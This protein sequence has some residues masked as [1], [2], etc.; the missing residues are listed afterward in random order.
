MVKRYPK[1]IFLRHSQLT[2]FPKKKD[3]T[4][5]T[6]ISSNAHQTIQAFAQNDDHEAFGRLAVYFTN[7]F[8][9]GSAPIIQVANAPVFCVFPDFFSF[10]R[11]TRCVARRKQSTA[12]K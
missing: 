2:L 4:E 12:M 7:W 11:I 1:L 5:S 10:V 3:F 9:T 8:K 6:Y